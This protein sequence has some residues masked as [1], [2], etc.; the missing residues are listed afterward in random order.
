MPV[1]A[2]RRSTP[3]EA[4]A[5]IPNGA[6][7][8]VNAT[9]GT[10]F[11]L[12]TEVAAQAHRFSSLELVAGYLLRAPAPYALAGE[13]GP[14]RITTTQ[15]SGATRALARSGAL[16]IVPAKYSDYAWLFCPPSPL[17]CDVALVQ[18]STPGP[19]GRV[20]LGATV[21]AAVEVVR[22]AALVIAQVNP[23]MPYT[24]GDGELPLDA[25]DHLV[26][27][28]EP[29]AVL[30]AA[31]ADD[32]TRR[33]AEHAASLVPD[34]ATIQFG[35]GAL[36]EAILGLLGDRRGLRVHSGMIAG[37]CA[38]L[39]AR[40][41]IDGEL[42]AAE[43]IGDRDLLDWVDRNPRV[44]LVR[45]AVSHGLAGL[46]RVEGLV[47][48]NSTVEV[49]LDGSANSEVVN[50]E[51]ISGPGGAPD[52][53]F[54]AASGILALPSTAAGGTVSR[55]VRRLE[56]PARTT[57]PGYLVDR[58]VTEHGVAA[59]RGLPLGARAEALAAIAAPAFRDALLAD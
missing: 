28:D 46:S 2:A 10:P 52:Y 47:G 32:V 24:F 29:L 4:V 25:F 54:G 50:G 39:V 6:R 40:G 15:A 30:P 55:I 11:G 57:I 36:P 35:I 41:A 1:R 51:V 20:S 31:T 22:T 58:V 49:A 42:V 13:G 12:L 59:L 9:S 37:S 44:R 38:D 21:G 56:P 33:V 8:F 18:V 26:D 5:A 53:A 16:R 3:A 27:I 48:I 14:F 23:Q 7:C 17:A 34:G 43:V 19:D 45:A